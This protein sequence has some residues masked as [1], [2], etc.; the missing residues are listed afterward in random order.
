[1]DVVLHL[2]QG[3]AAS[4]DALIDP[5]QVEA[6]AGEDR[7]AHLLRLELEGDGLE[8]AVHIAPLE[9]S[10]LAALVRAGALRE[11]LRQRREV[12]ARERPVADLERLLPRAWCLVLPRAGVDCEARV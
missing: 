11:L 8:V 4:G 6:A 1:A 2:I 3:A 5:Q 10:E 9:G 12:A 7:L